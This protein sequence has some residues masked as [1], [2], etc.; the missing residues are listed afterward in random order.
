MIAAPASRSPKSRAAAKAIMPPTSTPATIMLLAPAA[1]APAM[2]VLAISAFRIGTGSPV[3]LPV[4]GRS[5]AR[6]K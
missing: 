6:T 1:S 4:P 2:I 5:N 3:D